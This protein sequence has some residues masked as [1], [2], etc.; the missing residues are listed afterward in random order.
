MLINPAL[1]FPGDTCHLDPKQTKM[2]EFITSW[3]VVPNGPPAIL[4]YGTE[5]D[6]LGGGRVFT[7]EMIAA[8][9]RAELYTAAGQKN[10]FANDRAGSPWH[11]LVL[12]QSD[13][14]L[15]SLGFLK[16]PPTISF[17]PGTQATLT[18]DLP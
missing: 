12:R 2:R 6:L 17:P 13:L 10:G 3:K 7:K 18:N 11:A 16:S 5:D 1:S 15:S 4:F 8:R 14:F 9:N